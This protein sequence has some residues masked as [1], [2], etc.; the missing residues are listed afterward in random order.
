[1][2]DVPSAHSIL[3]TS[4]SRSS[5]K[6]GPG[7]ALQALVLQRM[8]RHLL[9]MAAL[10]DMKQGMRA[11]IKQALRKLDDEVMKRESETHIVPAHSLMLPQSARM[12]QKGD[13]KRSLRFTGAAISSKV[14]GSTFMKD[15]R[16]VGIYIHAERLREVDTTP[17]LQHFVPPA[18][19][20]PA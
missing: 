6:L 8:Q 7:N 19:A 14:L 15:Q 5:A 10:V 12:W 20:L 3:V 2:H 17:I 13:T 4:Q 16:V 18:G 11:Q 1:M 9:K